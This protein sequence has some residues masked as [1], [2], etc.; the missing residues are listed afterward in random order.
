MDCQRVKSIVLSHLRPITDY[1]IMGQVVGPEVVRAV[2]IEELRK[3]HDTTTRWPPARF[4]TLVE[5]E[6][7]PSR[8]CGVENVLIA[9]LFES[10]SNSV[11]KTSPRPMSIISSLSLQ[12]FDQPS[13]LMPLSGLI[14]ATPINEE[15]LRESLGDSL[16]LW[17]QMV[18]D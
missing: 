15:F 1:E 8:A 2:H 17:A 5:Q 6:Q 7:M 18:G 10:I 14:S 4:R 12:I 16:L 13:P 9:A 3:R 11:W